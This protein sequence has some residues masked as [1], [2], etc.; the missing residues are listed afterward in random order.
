MQ[1][2]NTLAEFT[3]YLSFIREKSIIALLFHPSRE[4]YFIARRR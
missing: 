2:G 3:I 4:I 1:A